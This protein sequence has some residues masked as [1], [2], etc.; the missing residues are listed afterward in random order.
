[1][2]SIDQD[3]S[4][5]NF[6]IGFYL[7]LCF[8]FLSLFSM[9]DRKNNEITEM[10]EQRHKPR[11]VVITERCMTEVFHEIKQCFLVE[12]I[13]AICSHKFL[14]NFVHFCLNIIALER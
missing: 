7:N 2:L 14:D 1:M 9:A 5:A 11:L 6:S 12:T 13:S 4:Y 10:N 8:I 3:F